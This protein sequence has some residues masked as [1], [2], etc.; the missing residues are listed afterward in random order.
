MGLV[1]SYFKTPSLSQIPSFTQNEVIDVRNLRINLENIEKEDDVIAYER[2]KTLEK[3]I[4]N[5]TPEYRIE[6]KYPEYSIKK[7]VSFHE[8]IPTDSPENSDISPKLNILI[9]V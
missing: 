4:F 5:I 3:E 2:A 6:Y 9:N 1:Y 7:S 8:L